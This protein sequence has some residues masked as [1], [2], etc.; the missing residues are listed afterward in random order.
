[1]QNLDESIGLARYSGPGEWNDLVSRP[2]PA[3]RGVGR[4]AG[5]KVP[6]RLSSVL[7]A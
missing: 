6:L 5:G 3:A 1:M 7:G 2:R 4:L